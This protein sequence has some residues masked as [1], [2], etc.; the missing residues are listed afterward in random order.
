M[1]Y[2]SPLLAVYGFLYAIAY[3]PINYSRFISHVLPGAII[4]L[5]K[6]FN[7]GTTI[8]LILLWA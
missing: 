5:I 2:N 7:G 3:P 1:D 4:E 8:A 6:C